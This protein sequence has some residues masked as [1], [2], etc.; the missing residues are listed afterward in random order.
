[1]EILQCNADQ[2]L[3]VNGIFLFFIASS[4]NCI[5]NDGNY[6][7][8]RM[9]NSNSTLR[10]PQPKK[11][12]MPN[13][14]TPNPWQSRWDDR[15]REEGFAYG[16]EPNAFLKS[17]L[18]RLVPGSILFPAEGEGRNAVYAAT[19]GW[20]VTAF[21]IAAEGQKKAM[22]LAEQNKVDIK[23][24]VG[25]L[26]ELHFAPHSFDT[27]ALIYAH[28]PADVKSQ[29]HT[30]LNALLKIGAVVIFEAFSKNHLP[31]VLANEKVGGPKDI[32]SLFSIEEIKADFCNYEIIELKE[33]VIELHEGLYHNGFASVI[34]FV[35]RKMRH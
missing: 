23:Y 35:G 24:L 22:Q 7:K 34:R 16:V 12:T 9:S 29:L 5:K 25:Y 30:M 13:T 20:T 33:E 19:Q 21:D 11:E 10:H 14:P 4:K 15:Y 28:F 31:Y 6:A 18:S 27:M 2:K 17:Q 32:D 3:I 1:M 26:E 8:S